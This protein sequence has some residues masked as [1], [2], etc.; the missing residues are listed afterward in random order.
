VQ[1]YLK[2]YR[3]MMDTTP[4]VAGGQ[5]AMDVND[6]VKAVQ[7]LKDLAEKQHKTFEAVMLENPE[8]TART[9]TSAHRPNIS[10]TSGSELQRSRPSNSRH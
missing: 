7:Q 3:D 6:P 4:R 8:L 2:S 10:S 9:Y 5:D 1:T